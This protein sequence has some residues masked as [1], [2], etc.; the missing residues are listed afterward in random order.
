MSKPVYLLSGEE[1]LADEALERIRDETGADPLSEVHLDGGADV[2]ELMGALETPSLLGGVR[3]VVVRSAGDLRKEQVERLTRYIDEPSPGSVLVLIASAKTKLDAQVKKAGAMVTLETPKGR[4]LVGWLRERAKE[5]AL[6]LDD[7]GAWTM[8]DAVGTELR[9]LDGALEQL[10]TRLGAGAAVGAVDVRKAFPRLADQRIFA[11]TDAV[12]DRKL[13]VAMASLRRLL[14]Q[15]DEPLVVFGA[16]SGQVR[17]MLRARR[18]ADAG[19]SA[20]GAA[21]ALPGWRA[22]RLTRQARAYREDEL[23]RALSLLASTDV[24]LKSGDSEPESALERAVVQ[25]IG[26]R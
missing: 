7:R 15:G 9:D 11:F 2:A 26:V 19:P 12:G 6:K 23:I 5:H 3:L 8:L 25:I 10:Q 13:P 4:K 24:E 17:R 18:F 16:L 20:V 21:M 1:F 14:E 22:E